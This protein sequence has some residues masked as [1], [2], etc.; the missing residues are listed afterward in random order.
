MKSF[1]PQKKRPEDIQ[2]TPSKEDAMTEE[3]WTAF[4]RGVKLFNSGK[5]W[6][7]HEA[8]EHVWL[9]HNEDE[10]LFFQGLIQLAAAY[11]QL[12]AKRNHRGLMNNFDKAYAKL[13][14]FQPEY[15]GIFVI[16]LLKFIQQGKQEAERVSVDG[17]EHFNHNMIPK[18][19][20]HKQSNPDLLVEIH[21]IIS[22]ERFLEGVKLFNAGYHW[23]A[24]EAWE[25]VWREQEGDAKTFIQAFVQTAAAYSF[26]KVSKFSSAVYLL[27]KALEKFYPYER[28]DRDLPLGPF[29][30]SIQ[31]TLEELK[32]HAGNGKASLKFTCAPTLVL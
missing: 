13:E 25:D 7:A 19:Q 30:H 1:R 12:I 28:V 27:E 31:C 2:R 24:H 3:D 17:L 23:E 4:E 20:F 29:I 16:P 26:I 9:R 6:Q 18:L 8:W 11:H 22:S 10:R 5:F 32:Q 14:V 15:L 21:E